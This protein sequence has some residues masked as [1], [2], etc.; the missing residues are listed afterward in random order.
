MGIRLT[1]GQPLVIAAMLAGVA[2]LGVAPAVGQTYPDRLIR[3]VVPFAA[4]G[5]VDVMARLVAQRMAVI[6]GQNVI[7]ENRAG[8]GGVIGAKAVA[9][10]EPDG[11][12]LL[13]GN[14]STL[15]VIPAVARNKDYDPVKS[16]VPVAKVSDSPEVLAVERSFP[17]RTVQ[18]LVTVAR[19]NPGKLNFGSAG[20][21]SAT[22]LA[23]EWF[24]A[25]TAVDV[26]HVPY[27]GLS[28]VV[29][30]VLAGQLTFVF[31]AIEGLMPHI[32]D[33]RLRALAVTSEKRFPLLPELP[34]MIES[35]VDGF[36]V[37]SFQGVVAPAGTPPAVV[38][39]LNAAVNASMEAPEMRAQLARLGATPAPGTPQEFAVFFAA[40]TRKW[41]AIV[42]SAGIS[43]D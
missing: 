25:K 1:L 42:K 15:A 17:A 3:I 19:N 28:E 12:T 32:Q 9:N 18:D 41:A 31:G 35:G 22:H 13:F 2:C 39:R 34:T 38:A 14:V 7:I 37:S 21:G 20:F 24:K 6:L 10:A 40:E 11:Y 23:A 43:I 16:F 26:V 8:G 27:K 4:G 5:P 30:G 36:V 29:T 33:G